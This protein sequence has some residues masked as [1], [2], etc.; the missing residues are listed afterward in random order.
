[1]RVKTRD[2]VDVLMKYS[3]S[4]TNRVWIVGSKKSELEEIG[5]EV[6]GCHMIHMGLWAYLIDIQQYEDYLTKY[7]LPKLY[8]TLGS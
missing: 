5:I 8:Y 7:N 4:D 3:D 6:Y 1:M 2:K